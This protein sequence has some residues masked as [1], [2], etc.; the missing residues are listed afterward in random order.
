[1]VVKGSHQSV[2]TDYIETFSYVVEFVIIRVILTYALYNGWELRQVD[3]NIAFLQGI[4]YLKL[5]TRN[6]QVVLLKNL[7]LPMFAN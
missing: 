2:D 7:P 1:M 3:I 6:N 4:S 5:S